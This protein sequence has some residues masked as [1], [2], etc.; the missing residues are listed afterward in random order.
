MPI[1]PGLLPALER[2]LEHAKQVKPGGQPPRKDRIA[3]IEEQIA[4]HRA[5][6]GTPETA[7]PE[8]GDASNVPTDYESHDDEAAV[9][10]AEAATE[11]AAEEAAKKSKKSPTKRGADGE[12]LETATTTEVAETA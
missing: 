12:D 11:A 4:L 8:K 3:A 7:A 2:E 5:V 6:L 1:D 9:A 10:K